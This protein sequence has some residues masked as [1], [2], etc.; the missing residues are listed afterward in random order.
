[1]ARA[2]PTET[3][4]L[5]FDLNHAAGGGAPREFTLRGDGKRRK[6][7]THTEETRRAH[8]Q[9]NPAL[10]AMPAEQ[11]QRLSERLKSSGR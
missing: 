5:H 6:L 4:T 2:R 1:M 10:A 9:Q 11:L 7:V 8:A 3:V